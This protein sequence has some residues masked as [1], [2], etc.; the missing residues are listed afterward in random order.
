MQDRS[1]SHPQLPHAETSRSPP[2]RQKSRSP[3]RLVKERCSPAKQVVTLS[4][5]STVL[6][7]YKQGESALSS[8]KLFGGGLPRPNPQQPQKQPDLKPGLEESGGPA[9]QRVSKRMMKQP[10]S[11]AARK[12]HLGAHSGHL[13]K[14]D[15]SV[16]LMPSRR[17]VKPQEPSH[18]QKQMLSHV[19][20]LQILM[21]ESSCSELRDRS[22][23]K[24]SPIQEEDDGPG[25]DCHSPPADAATSLK[26]QVN[27][28]AAKTIE[29]TDSASNSAQ[30]RG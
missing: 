4:Y 19:R 6:R 5:P 2:P 28:S 7:A 15:S 23:A 3:P 18:P 22:L 20:Q 9:E 21:R 26:W 25:S 12:K 1:E 16:M 17:S 24:A 8:P 29:G 30:K 11:P 10:L 14:K 13:V 27:R